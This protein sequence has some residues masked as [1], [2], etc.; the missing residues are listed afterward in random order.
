MTTYSSSLDGSPLLVVLPDA[1]ACSFQRSSSPIQF[2]S[3]P[4]SLRAA[5]ALAP[6]SGLERSFSFFRGTEGGLFC[7]PTYSGR[8]ASVL[9]RSL[10][11]PN[12]Y[13]FFSPRLSR[14]SPTRSAAPSRE[15]IPSLF[16]VPED[17]VGS[18]FTA[19]LPIVTN[20][21]DPLS[22]PG[23]LP[24]CPPARARFFFPPF[25]RRR[26]LPP[27]DRSPSF[28]SPSRGLPTS[29]PSF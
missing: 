2:L 5:G 21:K 23:P 16:F 6:E 7:P 20:S 17:I 4:S 8:F 11:T 14:H 28:I 22:S 29:P 13:S 24:V 27:Y 19:A 26:L 3:V 15:A 1:S 10:S 12:C 9:P 18:S 25:L